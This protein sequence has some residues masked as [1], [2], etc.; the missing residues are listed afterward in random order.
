MS[1][2]CDPRYILTVQKTDEQLSRN[3]LTYRYRNDDDFGRPDSTFTLC[4]F[5]MISALFKIGQKDEAYHRFENLISYMNHLGLID[6]AVLLYSDQGDKQEQE[7]I[8]A[9]RMEL[10]E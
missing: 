4:S 8:Y 2:F 10:A 1:K 7:N 6:T 9:K 5:W 3:G